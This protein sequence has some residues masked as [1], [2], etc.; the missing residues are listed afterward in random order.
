MES[1]F[2]VK[3][4]FVHLAFKSWM[5]RALDLV[6]TKYLVIKPVLNS[7]NYEFFPNIPIKRQNP[8]T[9]SDTIE[10]TEVLHAL[11]QKVIYCQFL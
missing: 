2:I 7:I 10:S 11:G 9:L 3:V 6:I 5:V 1:L 4:G 8:L